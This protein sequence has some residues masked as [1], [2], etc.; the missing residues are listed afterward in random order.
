MT[1]PIHGVRRLWIVLGLMWAAVFVLCAARAQ[2]EVTPL[3]ASGIASVRSAATSDLAYAQQSLA[4]TEAAMTDTQYPTITNASG[5]WQHSGANY[6]TSG[7]FPGELWLMYQLTGDT[8]W[9]QQA[10]ERQA[11]LA[12][13][14]YN[15]STADVGFMLG[16]S[17]G[18]GYRLTGDPSYEQVLLNGAASLASRY[19]PVV[20]S[21][22]SWNDSSSEP[23][24][25]FIVIVDNMM[26]LNLL[27]SGWDQPGGNAA[28]YTMAVNHS[29][30]T[31]Q[32]FI[33][34][35][36]ST[37]HI[38]T[39]NGD[40]GAV[41]SKYGYFSTA[42]TWSR[43]QAWAI[44]GFTQAYDA[45]GNTAFLGA[46]EKAAQYYHYSAPSNGVPYYDFDAAASS[47][48][49][50]DSSAAAIA[51]SAFV[52]LAKDLPGTTLGTR[53]LGDAGRILTTL[54]SPAFLS[55]GTTAQSILLQGTAD[56]SIGETDD[57]T[58]YGDYYFIEALERYLAL[59]G[60]S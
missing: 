21:T 49:P 14:Q 60:S 2:A 47:N 25:D 4:A 23:A 5:V 59:E 55:K 37:Y 35:D 34:S 29:V 56:E 32:Q 17:F 11:G 24:S 50:V 16:T 20:R 10:Q 30:R 58:V 7:F 33:R 18:N 43:G 46:A 19:S 15:T 31:M 28:W 27:W 22:R 45:T 6:W 57:G 44:Y 9:E 13:Q 48:P 40:T 53:Y 51:A 41:Q 26:N 8:S 54:S 36:G 38:V 42:S 12:A 39:Y 1:A 3:P 52:E